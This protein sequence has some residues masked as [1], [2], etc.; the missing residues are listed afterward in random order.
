MEDS[1]RAFLTAAVLASS[2][3]LVFAQNDFDWHG[4]LG[5]GQT[6]EIK[7]ING[8]VHAV[9]SPNGD[10]EVHATKTARRG[11]PDAVRIQV[12]TTSGGVTVCAVYPDVPGEEPNSCQP[13]SANP[14]HVKDNDTT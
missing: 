6:L 3:V 5:S 10:A 9:A 4:Q 1:M 8:D 2:A 7:G 12:V 13:G 14:S 11:N